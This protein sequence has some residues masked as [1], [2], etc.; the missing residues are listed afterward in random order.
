M[1]KT[2]N[3][4]LAGYPFTIDEDAF[5]LLKDYLDT[6]RYAFDTN[7]D[8]GEIAADI[9]SRIAELLIENENGGIRIVTADEISRVIERIG[10]PSDFIEI[11]ET[12]GKAGAYYTEN[13]EGTKEK[14]PDESMNEEIHIEEERITPPPY[15]SGY[16]SRNP[17]VRRKFFRDTR[18]S[19]LGGVCAGLAYYLNIDVTIVRI[20]TILLFFLSGTTV[21]FAYIILWIIVPEAN[22]P[23]QRMKMMGQNPTVENIG[24][25][26]TENF[27]KAEGS[28]EIEPKSVFSRFINNLF[29]ICVKGLV[30][31]GLLIACPVLLALCLAMIG[32]I[33]AVFVIVVG[34]L[35]GLSDPYWMF[36][37]KTECLFAFY[38]LLAVIGGI[39]TVGIPLWLFVRS[40]WKKQNNNPQTNQNTR[41]T[42]LIIWLC[43]IALLSVFTVKAV[44]KGRHLDRLGKIIEWEQFE[45]V[46]IDEENLENIEVT[47]GKI[48]VTGDNGKQVT[49]R[50]GKITVEKTET[51]ET[52]VT[53]ESDTVTNISET[54]VNTTDSI[55]EVYSTIASD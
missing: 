51:P 25:T 11:N 16:T 47:P 54:I 48:K 50:P 10:K 46:D 30:L 36:E 52:A 45:N 21:A 27:N 43:G 5:Q 55:M 33:I 41:R 23:L 44:K 53:V 12:F 37:S 35:G 7:D 31:V 49:I 13:Q 3:I 20:I 4:N 6:I 18:N 9:E 8:T 2:V 39:I 38:I 1:K 14:H 19:I 32:C 26:V 29:S 24:R 42:L 40:V 22:T 17:F 28:V 34:I 15:N